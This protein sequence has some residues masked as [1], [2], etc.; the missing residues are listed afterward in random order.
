LTITFSGG[1]AALDICHFLIL[2][3]G[4]FAAYCT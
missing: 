2:L 3:E 4:M 1:S